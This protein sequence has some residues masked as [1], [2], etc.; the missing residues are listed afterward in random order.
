M[1]P[2][3]LACLWLVLTALSSAQDTNF[4][5]GPQYL[6]NF[7]SP[8]LLQPIATPSLSFALPPASA[9][10]AAAEASAE[11]QSVPAPATVPNKTDLPRIYYGE[12]YVNAN[13][14]AKVSENAGELVSEI[15]LS[16][17]SSVPPA[18]IA[19]DGVAQMVDEQSLRERAYGLSLAETAA[20]WKTHKPRASHVYTNADIARLH[21]G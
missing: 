3:S 15:E 12:S 13:T 6:M 9:P 8:L 2:A 1:R 11:T 10:V 20:F 5:V 19:G 7:G 21:R 17:K 18:S 4:P 16:S 14:G